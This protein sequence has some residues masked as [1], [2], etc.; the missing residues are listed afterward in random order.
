MPNVH[1]I[2]KVE[3]AELPAWVQHFDLALM[4]LCRNEL[5]GVSHPN[6]LYEYSASG[7]PVLSIDYCSAVQRARDVLQV[8]AS[9]E[10]FVRM[11]PEALADSRREARQA[12]AR[13]HSWDVL[14]ATMVQ[15][16]QNAYEEQSI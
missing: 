15:E 9:P 8:A 2:G 7:V 16:L 10:E 3:Y 5:K 4:P 12:F 14:A 1:Y 11:I 6:K 13:G